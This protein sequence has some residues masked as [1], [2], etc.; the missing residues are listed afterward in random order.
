M[1][2]RAHTCRGR[3]SKQ[4]WGRVLGL[5]RNREIKHTP[6]ELKHS[7]WNAQGQLF[8]D[9]RGD[10]GRHGRGRRDDWHGRWLG[11]GLIYFHRDWLGHGLRPL[12]F[13]RFGMLLGSVSVFRVLAAMGSSLG[14]GLASSLARTLVAFTIGRRAVAL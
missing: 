7:S 6:L 3:D 1:T 10:H 4:D 2:T 13:G 12:S 5:D 8:N 9:F 14:D 11:D